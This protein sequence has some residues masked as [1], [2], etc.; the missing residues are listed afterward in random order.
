MI[1][2]SVLLHFLE[3]LYMYS[4]RVSA[5]DQYRFVMECRNSGL[6]DYQWCLSHDIKPGTFYNWVK[7]LRQKGCNDIPAVAGRG[8][9]KEATRQEV[10][11]IDFSEPVT[12]TTA[13]VSAGVSDFQSSEQLPSIE[14]T[15]GNANIRIT[16]GVDPNLLAQTIR[17]IKELIC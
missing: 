9:Y 11:R 7:R 10:V 2:A 4:L 17:I 8:S 3:G 13:P 16:N 1:D 6:S 15:L 12:P 5:E 14:L